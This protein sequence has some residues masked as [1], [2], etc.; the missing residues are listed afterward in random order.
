MPD[1]DQILKIK[2]D[3]ESKLRSLPG[4]HAV[5]IGKKSV[6]GKF[7]ND[8]AITVFVTEK[9]PLDQLSPA[10]VIPAEIDGV[11]TDVVQTPIP[12]L[13]STGNPANL[14]ATVS[15]NQLSVTLTGK[16][17]PGG[18]LLVVLHYSVGP[19]G[20]PATH[21]VE[22][23]QPASWETLNDIATAFANALTQRNL[24]FLFTVAL[25]GPTLT[26]TAA[27]N[28][29]VTIT[30]CVVT[31]VDDTRYID[32]HLRGGIQIQAGSPGQ[33][34]GTIGFLATTAVTPQ[35]PQGKVVAVTCQHVVC[36]PVSQTSN[37]VSAVAGNQ[38]AFGLN[39]SD[40][41]PLNTLVDVTFSTLQADVFYSTWP[42]IRPTAWPTESSP[43]SPLPPFRESV[44]AR[45][46]LRR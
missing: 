33:G 27:A 3:A 10:E 36:P 2:E 14:V 39:T 13:I 30:S 43:P 45:R 24:N 1:Y 19:T 22:S 23:Y 28:F 16:N 38:I 11:K 9:K 12:Q 32:D 7:T 35:D 44:R 18:G 21:F 34:Q 6:G 15:G 41:I 42:E 5:G 20:S 4:V 46:R 29:T 40:P 26:F 25:A 31:A 8:L 17:I 37:L